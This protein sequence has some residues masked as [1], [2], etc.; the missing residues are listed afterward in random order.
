LN[1][2]KLGR[3][4][5]GGMI[6]RTEKVGKKLEERIKKLEGGNFLNLE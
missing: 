3:G 4:F 6:Y 2:R 1:G 5:L